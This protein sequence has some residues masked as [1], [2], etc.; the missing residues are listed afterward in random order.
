MIVAVPWKK[1]TNLAKAVGHRE[2]KSLLISLVI[3][4]SKQNKSFIKAHKNG[5][6]K[7]IRKK[8]NKQSLHYLMQYIYL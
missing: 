7:K 2:I 1:I 8:V 6:N 4:S 3:S 5:S